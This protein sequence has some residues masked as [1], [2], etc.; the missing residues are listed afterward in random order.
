MIDDLANYDLANYDLAND[1]LTDG[2]SSGAP[3]WMQV[4]SACIRNQPGREYL[5][6]S[7]ND[8][9]DVEHAWHATDQD[10]WMT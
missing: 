5:D 4:D 7:G 10:G 1:G 2:G 8:E 6:E 3:K 9:G